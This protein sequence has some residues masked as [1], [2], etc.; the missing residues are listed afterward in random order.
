MAVLARLEG[1]SAGGHASAR[2]GHL[3]DLRAQG[4]PR[5]EA[6]LGSAQVPGREPVGRGRR[7]PR[8]QGSRPLPLDGGPGLPETKAF[9]EAQNALSPLGA[10][11]DRGQGGPSRAAHRPLELPAHRPARPRGGSPLLRAGTRASRSRR[12]S[13]CATRWRVRLASSSTRT[14]SRPTVRSPSRSG[15]SPPTGGTWPTAWPRAARTGEWSACGRSP[16]ARTSTTGSSG[17]ASRGSRGRR[18]ARASSTRASPSRPR[19]RRW[20]P[21]SSTRSSTT[22]GWARPR[23]QDRLIYERPDLP[24]WFVGGGA[25]ED[26]RYLIVSIAGRNGSEEPPLLRGPGRSPPPDGSTPPS[27]PSWTRTSP[28][29]AWSA[30][31]GRASSSAP[32]WRRRTAGS[33]PSIRACASAGRGGRP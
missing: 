16:P 7:L 21:P 12:P 23:R 30:T 33:S 5:E 29:S 14:P 6:V 27:S 11:R 24:K 9:I 32:T 25:T 19:A 1:G 2:S 17:S 3:S 15:P 26:G 18:T 8:D 28:S 13:T 10:R 22:T 20:R 4:G 31:R